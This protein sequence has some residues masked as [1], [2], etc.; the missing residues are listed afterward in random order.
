MERE[1]EHV[2]LFITIFAIITAVAFF[3]IALA[4]GL[5]FLFAIVYGL[6]LVLVANVPEGLPTTVVTV[7]TLTAQRMAEHNIFI[8][9][10][11]IIEMLGAGG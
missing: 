3:V 7:L 2:V 8:K 5:G 10:T 9:R 4:R 11:Q 6:V 1:I